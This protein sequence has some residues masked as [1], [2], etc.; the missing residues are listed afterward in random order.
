MAVAML[1]GGDHVHPCVEAAPGDGR[2]VIAGEP[3]EAELAAAVGA[4]LLVPAEKLAIVE[5]RHLVEA[6]R[7][8]RLAPYR[9][10]GVGGDARA[11][12]GVARDAAVKCER[13]VAERPGDQVFGVIEAGLLPAYPAVRRAVRVKR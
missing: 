10:N 8:K 7:R 1:A 3:E 13:A 11:Q 5:G 6:L 9:D 4:H 12:A 2:D